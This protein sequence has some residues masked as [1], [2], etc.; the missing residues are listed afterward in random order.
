MIGIIQPCL[1]TYLRSYY[2]YLLWDLANT[3]HAE[4]VLYVPGI[5]GE[6][7]L[8]SGACNL[9]PNLAEYET[10]DLKIAL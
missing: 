7:S 1:A 9:R 2:Y 8:S 10:L 5:G 3:P 4:P 6:Y